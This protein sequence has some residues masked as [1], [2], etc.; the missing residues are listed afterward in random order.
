M[1][2]ELR[3]TQCGEGQERLE[4]VPQEATFTAPA[5]HGKQGEMLYFYYNRQLLKS[6]KQKSNMIFIG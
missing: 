6:L 4:G 5:D 3:A 1:I 2:P